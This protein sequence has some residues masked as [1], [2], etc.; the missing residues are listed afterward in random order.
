MCSS[1][2]TCTSSLRRTHFTGSVRLGVKDTVAQPQTRLL[3]DLLQVGPHG[4]CKMELAR[5]ARPTFSLLSNPSRD[6]LC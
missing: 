4:L 1:A 5:L 2:Q 3:A 6:E